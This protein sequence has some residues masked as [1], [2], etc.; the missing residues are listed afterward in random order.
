MIKNCE[1]C[2][3]VTSIS[4]DHKYRVGTLIWCCSVAASQEVERL[5]EVVEEVKPMVSELLGYRVMTG[6]AHNEDVREAMHKI[7]QA[8]APNAEPEDK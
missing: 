1:K 8:L 3:G 7:D 4:T 2:G 5:R 6:S